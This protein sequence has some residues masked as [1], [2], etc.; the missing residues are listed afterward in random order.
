L[1]PAIRAPAA[2]AEVRHGDCKRTAFPRCP[3]SGRRI[4]PNVPLR[5][6]TSVP[7]FIQSALRPH[8]TGAAATADIM[9]VLFIGG[10]LIFVAV[11]ALVL[12]AQFGRRS[13]WLAGRTVVWVG[14][15]AF[16]VVV[17]FALLLYTLLAAARIDSALGAP[18][19]RIEVVGEQWWWRVHY[20]DAAGHIDFAAANEI[21]V[22]VGRTVELQLRSADVLH[23][24]WVPALAG[25][26]DLIPGK[27]N[28]LVL[29]ADRPG[30][31]RGQCAEFCGG[32]HAQ[33]ALF[34][35]AEA[36]DGFERW[37]T[38]QRQPAAAAGD[39][40]FL[41]R[42]SV[43]H[44]VRGTAAAGALGPDLTHVGSRLSLGAGIL[45]NDAETAAAWITSNQHIK[46]GN[47]MP[48]FADLSAAQVAALAR[49][50]QSLQ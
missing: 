2:V 48:Q 26:L 32:P 45:A 15:I 41:A 35:V 47:L 22:P 7:E 18:E 33:M 28:R 20:F 16:P 24:L 46:P 38:A 43:C 1:L 14:G 27:V 36:H 21:H 49:Y 12:W 50:L 8:G 42:C 34:V 37:R 13:A 5:R 31:F 19:L 10:G 23:S 39:A 30:T 17:L 11:V 6:K 25:K 3:A 44:A 40:L 29:R 4:V 9:W